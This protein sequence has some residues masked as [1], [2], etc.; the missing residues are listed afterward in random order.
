MDLLVLVKSMPCNMIHLL[1]DTIPGTAGVHKTVANELLEIKTWRLETGLGH[2]ET[3]L[4]SCLLLEGVDD[5]CVVY[6]GCWY[7]SC[8]FRAGSRFAPSQWE[9]ALLYNDVSHCLGSSLESA[10]ILKEKGCSAVHLSY[11][12]HV[13]SGYSKITKDVTVIHILNHVLDLAWP[14]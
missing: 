4:V 7:C 5:Q 9:T 11:T 2:L 13:R 8:I 6:T 14:K 3:G 12:I 1:P 10:L